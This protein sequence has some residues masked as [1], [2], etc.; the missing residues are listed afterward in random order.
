MQDLIDGLPEE[1]L[2]KTWETVD[3]P[4][5]VGVLQRVL[6]SVREGH[7]TVDTI[8]AAADVVGPTRVTKSLGILR[9]AHLIERTELGW[10]PLDPPT[11]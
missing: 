10:Y 11:A 1:W 8:G 6:S 5:E 7:S 3:G 9:D 4:V 2:G